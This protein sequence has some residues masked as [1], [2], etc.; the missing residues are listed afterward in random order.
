MN[1][2]KFMPNSRMQR[3]VLGIL[4]TTGL[5]TVLNEISAEK[6]TKIKRKPGVGRHSTPGV[7]YHCVA[8]RHSSCTKRNCT[9]EC[10]H[11]MF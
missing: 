1:N 8:G 11:R 2:S 4:N 5:H 9:C 7:S 10:G 6:P 3:G